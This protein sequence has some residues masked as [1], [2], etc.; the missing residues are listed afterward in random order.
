MRT[1]LVSLHAAALVVV[2]AAAG[3]AQSPTSP[4]YPGQAGEIGGGRVIPPRPTDPYLEEIQRRQ[5]REQLHQHYAD[6]KRDTDRLLQLATELKA[7]VDKAGEHTLSLEAIRK[8]EEIEKLA[9]SVRN[10]MKAP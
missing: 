4:P 8:T 2:L 9:R 5:A 7:Q 10:K 3:L 6:M 1:A